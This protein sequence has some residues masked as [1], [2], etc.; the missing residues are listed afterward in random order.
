MPN[1]VFAVGLLLGLMSVAV[2]CGAEQTS[3]G[4]PPTATSS[5]AE[6]EVRVVLTQFSEAVQNEDLDGILIFFSDEYESNE[7]T[8]K[9]AVREWWLRIVRS[10]QATS[11]PFDL[12]TAEL[13]V[14]GNV[15]EVAYYDERG[16]LACPNLETPCNSPQRYLDYSLEK[17]PQLGWLITGI[18]S[19][20]S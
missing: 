16:E 9:S 20:Q 8:G 12:G 19:E 10:G 6:D 1:L 2:G 13:D 3:V 17:D 5:S 4:D 15:A 11:L 18:P 14:D 7:A